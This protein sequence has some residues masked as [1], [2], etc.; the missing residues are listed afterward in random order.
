MA[1]SD[2]KQTAYKPEVSYVLTPGENGDE[3]QPVTVKTRDAAKGLAEFMAANAGGVRIVKTITRQVTVEEL[4][5]RPRKPRAAAA[6]GG[7]SRK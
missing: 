2:K 5:A 6:T 1:K 7:K 4:A 3:G